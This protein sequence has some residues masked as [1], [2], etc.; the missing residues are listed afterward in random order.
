MRTPTGSARRVNWSLA[1]LVLSLVVPSLAVFQKYSGVAGVAAYATGTTLILG[2]TFAHRHALAQG[3]AY[4][5]EKRALI[6][7]SL[8]FLGLLA[9]FPLVYPI[10]NPGIVGGGSDFDDALDLAADALLQGHYP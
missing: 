10:A 2:T 6:T 4:L 5:T 8:T 1:K 9:V 7:A 3:V